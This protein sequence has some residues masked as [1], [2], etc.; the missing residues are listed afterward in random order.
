[1]SVLYELIGRFVVGFARRRYGK[2]IRTAAAVS[3]AGVALLAAGAWA[4][5][6]DDESA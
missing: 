3:V 2:E 6:R 1:M 5:T 4:A